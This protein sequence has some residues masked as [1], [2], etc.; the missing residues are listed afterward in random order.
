MH[1]DHGAT[2]HK[3]LSLLQLVP[4]E[5]SNLHQWSDLG[6]R[7]GQGLLI[8]LLESNHDD[9]MQGRA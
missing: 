1:K 3:R 2:T 6:P 8:P 5:G 4:L 9:V 7:A